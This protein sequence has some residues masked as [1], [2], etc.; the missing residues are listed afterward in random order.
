M[1][2]YDK[3]LFHLPQRAKSTFTGG[4]PKWGGGG[5]G[6]SNI[7]SLG[8]LTAKSKNFATTV[9]NDNDNNDPRPLRTL[10]THRH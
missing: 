1:C 2:L 3:I 5:R 8:H 6:G 10:K 7:K 9:N 4:E